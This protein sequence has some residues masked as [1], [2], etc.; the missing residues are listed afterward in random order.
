MCIKVDRLPLPVKTGF[1]SLKMGKIIVTIR[2]YLRQWMKGA[3]PVACPVGVQN[4]AFMILF[5]TNLTLLQ[6]INKDNH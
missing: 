1:T 2:F 3:G 4:Q 6:L 5:V